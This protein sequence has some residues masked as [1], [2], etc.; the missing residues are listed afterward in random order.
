MQISLSVT[1]CLQKYYS[2]NQG[3]VLVNS[4]RIFKKY[5]KLNEEHINKTNKNKMQDFI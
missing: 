5:S 2:I 1:R 4:G 3:V